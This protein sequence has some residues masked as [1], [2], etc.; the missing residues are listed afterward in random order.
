MKTEE[1]SKDNLVNK[2]LTEVKNKPLESP[3]DALNINCEEILKLFGDSKE[4]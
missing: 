4:D 1:A 3:R 2:I